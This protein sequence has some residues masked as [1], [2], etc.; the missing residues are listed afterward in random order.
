[1]DG[2]HPLLCSLL[3]GGGVCCLSC[4]GPWCGVACAPPCPV[5]GSEYCGRVMHCLVAMS[6]GVV[7]VSVCL[8]CLCGGVSFVCHPPGRGGG[9]GIV[10]GGVAWRRGVAWR[11]KGGCCCTDLPSV[12]WCP[13]VQCWCPLFCSLGGLVEGWVVCCGVPCLRIGSSSSYC[14]VPLVSSCFSS[15][16]AWWHD[17]MRDGGGACYEWR[18]VW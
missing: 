18:G 10:D 16:C 1:M 9:G 7:R 13:L 12:C 15:V 8:R 5:H 11:V 14:L 17:A 3:N 4:P 2:V 6:C